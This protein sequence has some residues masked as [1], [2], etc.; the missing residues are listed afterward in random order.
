[1]LRGALS[2]WFMAG[3]VGACQT[4]ALAKLDPEADKQAASVPS[5]LAPAKPPARF[6]SKWDAANWKAR[7]TA[8]S[9][10]RLVEVKLEELRVAAAARVDNGADSACQVVEKT[11]PESR[12][13]LYNSVESK[14]AGAQR[15]VYHLRGEFALSADGVLHCLEVE[16][17][18]LGEKEVRLDGHPRNCRGGAFEETEP[19]SNLFVVPAGV[20]L[21]KPLKL[22]VPF[23]DV[24]YRY[25]ESCPQ[26]P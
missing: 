19:K 5:G 11:D 9:G 2:F 12:Q 14:G 13:M 24:G 3:A 25:K 7:K 10:A 17:Q 6:E 23:Y 1:M 16:L 18:S 4:S 8:L 21:G 15:L 26:V 20:R 22:R